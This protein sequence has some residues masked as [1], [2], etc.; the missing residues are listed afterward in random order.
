MKKK[1]TKNFYDTFVVA[2]LLFQPSFELIKNTNLTN[3]R[4]T[5]WQKELFNCELIFN[6]IRLIYAQTQI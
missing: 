1:K 2:K 3:Q 4:R 6:Q 5:K